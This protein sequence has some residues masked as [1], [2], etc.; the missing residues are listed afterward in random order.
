M[1]ELG[2][3]IDDDTFDELF[4]QISALAD[5]SESNSSQFKCKKFSQSVSAPLSSS[6]CITIQDENGLVNPNSSGDEEKMLIF[7]VDF[8]YNALLNQFSGIGGDANTT[9]QDVSVDYEI[10]V[11]CNGEV[12]ETI[13][14]GSFANVCFDCPEGSKIELCVNTVATISSGQPITGTFTASIC[15][16]SVCIATL[17][18][19]A[20]PGLFL[21][22]FKRDC[23]NNRETLHLV[24]QNIQALRAAFT[25]FGQIPSCTDYD[26]ADDEDHVLLA[27]ASTTTEFLVV[28]QIEVCAQNPFANQ[29][30]FLRLE[31]LITCGGG[32]LACEGKTY[33][34]GGSSIEDNAQLPNSICRRVPVIACGVCAPG[35]DIQVGVRSRVDCSELPDTVVQQGG[36][37]TSIEQHYCVYRFERQV[38]DFGDALNSSI[39]RCVTTELTDAINS[40]LE[41][42][43]LACE[44][45][46]EINLTRRPEAGTS[47]GADTVLIQEAQPWPPLDDPTNT[48]PV[49]VKKWFVQGSLTVCAARSN[50]TN[51]NENSD[52][53]LQAAV[54]CG[55][56]PVL[57]V[58]DSWFWNDIV[59]CNTI[60]FGRCVQCPIDQ[61][62]EF[63]FDNVLVGG[64]FPNTQAPELFEYNIKAFCF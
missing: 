47:T 35:E 22:V 45:Q 46:A 33:S 14:D 48:D 53:E 20:V 13:T 29:T 7:T 18:N 34:L 24:L 52:V 4:E 27:S 6:A 19:N 5:C 12:Q 30:A 17:Q 39:G 38:N 60:N 44:S 61:D 56:V 28:G 43:E 31:P 8:S 49:P 2:D 54:L 50:T 55:G 59:R 9:T 32:N 36:V 25:E 16:V 3:C 26:F 10:D 42:L 37:I 58:E 40:S 1:I 11:L 23:C 57:E 21:P 64:Q 41:L 51:R 15:G 62:L 63:S